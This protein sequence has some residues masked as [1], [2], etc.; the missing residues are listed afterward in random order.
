[1]HK[2]SAQLLGTHLRPTEPVSLN[3]MWCCTFTLDPQTSMYVDK[4]FS[5]YPTPCLTMAR[6]LAVQQASQITITTTLS[7]E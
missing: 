3:Q 1:M 5:L 2:R 7:R 4:E 6:H